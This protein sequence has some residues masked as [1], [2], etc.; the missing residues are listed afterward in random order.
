M[1]R[2][3]ESEI[4]GKQ[5]QRKPTSGGKTPRK[6]LVTSTNARVEKTKKRRFR[7]GTVAL[8]EIRR[9]QKSGDLLIRRLP[10]E[11]MVREIVQNE[12]HSPNLRVQSSAINALQVSQRLLSLNAPIWMDTSNYVASSRPSRFV[13]LECKTRN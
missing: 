6:N 4:A 1:A 7:P 2:T 5:G 13:P 12:E 3:K 8:R 11:R 10:F 9:Y